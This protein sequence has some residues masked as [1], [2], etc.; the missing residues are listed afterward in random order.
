MSKGFR[1]FIDGQLVTVFCPY[2]E[3]DGS[4]QTTVLDESGHRLGGYCTCFYRKRI[5]EQW[6]RTVGTHDQW[7]RLTKLVPSEKSALPV[8]AQ[9]KCITAMQ[10][11]PSGS[12]AMFGPSGAS[13][14]TFTVALY[15]KCL[16]DNYTN[17]RNIIR[18]KTKTLLET[19]QA[20]RYDDAFRSDH[21]PPF[22]TAERIRSQ[23]S[24]GNKTH[25]FLEE[26]EK[27]KYTENRATEIFDIIDA[28][29]EEGG[30]LVVT[31]NL[32]F[33]DLNDTNKFVEGFPRRI[34]EICGK[35]KWDFWKYT[36]EEVKA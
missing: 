17:A 23:A 13:K 16:F 12:Y 14:T 25:L 21:R 15:R 31:G 26:L 7:V 4:G 35:H 10:K 27:V 32:T 28:V 8:E 2:N 29:Y 19:I 5:D 36:K 34:D 20:Y 6:K 24:I 3:C 11:D 33:D 1:E 9:Q 22:T 30:Q 18:I